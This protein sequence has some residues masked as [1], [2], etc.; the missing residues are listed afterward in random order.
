MHREGRVYCLVGHGHADLMSE[1]EL[2]SYPMQL[3]N[4][5]ISQRRKALVRHD[6]LPEEKLVESFQPSLTFLRLNIQSELKGVQSQEEE[7]VK[8]PTQRNSIYLTPDALAGIDFSTTS[9]EEKKESTSPAVQKASMMFKSR[10]N[11]LKKRESGK[12]DPGQSK[13]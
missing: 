5:P 4:D 8:F 6:S 10:S 13:S 9:T 1:A 3:H 11:I 7:S 2:T 12:I